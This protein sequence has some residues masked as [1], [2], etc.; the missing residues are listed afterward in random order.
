MTILLDTQIFLWFLA[1]SPRLSQA[2]RRSIRDAAV[3]SVS[4]ASIWEVAI[5]SALGK[6]RIEPTRVMRGITASGFEELP[7]LARHAVLVA[8]LA[9]HHRDPFDRLLVFYW[10]GGHDFL[11]FQVRGTR[12]VGHA[13]WN[14][15]E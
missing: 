10:R 9:P 6:L 11:Y 14:A 2:A 12:I 7:V 1:D 13:W 5:K 4:A 15:G 3:V 8:A